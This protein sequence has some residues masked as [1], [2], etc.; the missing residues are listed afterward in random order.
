MRGTQSK[1]LLLGCLIGVAVGVAVVPWIGVYG[2]LTDTDITEVAR[3]ISA[4]ANTF[5]PGAVANIPVPGAP[6]VTESV[7]LGIAIYM[8]AAVGLGIAL[9]FAW[10]TL[11]PH[12]PTMDGFVFMIASLSTFAA[13][14]AVVEGFIG[15][16]RDTP[17]Y[18][19]AFTH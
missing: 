18:T 9:A 5:V 3:G 14:G 2:T 1:T 8:L 10:R 15:I 7:G 11:S 6:F 19:T 17:A 13:A 12:Q 16:A 4:V